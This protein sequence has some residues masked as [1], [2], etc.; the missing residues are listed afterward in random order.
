MSWEDCDDYLFASEIALQSLL[1]ANKAESIDEI[2]CDPLLAK[3]FDKKAAKFAPGFSSLEYRWAALKLRKQARVARTRGAVLTAP[4]KLG[5]L[6]ALE[7]LDLRSLPN[8][9]GVYVLSASESD[10]LYVGEALNLR[11][12]LSKQFG[13]R[14]RKAWAK[15]SSSLHVQTFPTETTVSDKLAWQSCFVKKYKPRLNFHEL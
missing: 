2:L 14:Q 4:S 11:G 1:D 3:K 8:E 13:K 7:D 6:T 12:R 5:Q 10:R 9:P 15:V